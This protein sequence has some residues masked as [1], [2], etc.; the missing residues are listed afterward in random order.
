MDDAV[1]LCGSRWQKPLIGYLKSRGHKVTIVNPVETDT[2]AIANRVV[3]EDV[4]S[5]DK[6]VKALDNPNFIVSNESD[7][8]SESLNEVRKAFGHPYNTKESIRL[9]S[10]KGEMYKFAKKIGVPVN[11]FSINAVDFKEYPKVVKPVDS[12]NSRGFTLVSSLEEEQEAIE[13]ALS[14]SFSNNYIVQDYNPGKVQ[15]VVEGICTDYKHQTISVGFKGSYMTPCYCGT[16][17]WPYEASEELIKANDK[18]VNESGLRFGLTHA[19]YIVDGDDFWLNE[20][21]AR[22]GGY[23]VSSLIVPW[24]SGVNNLEIICDHALGQVP[25]VNP[26]KTERCALLKFFDY[27]VQKP[28]HAIDFSNSYLNSSYSKNENPRKSYYTILGSDKK[29]LD[30][31]TR[32]S[33]AFIRSH[34]N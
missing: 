19:E 22:G 8:V 11:N 20:I 6:I 26:L 12:C 16:I 27:L 7:I 29:D 17:R 21:A 32:E 10:D 9:F 15:L 33:D 23:H 31:K 24:V 28:P 25:V 2:T 3:L 4:R 14:N 13:Y 30:N 34:N 1:V 18:F 5:V